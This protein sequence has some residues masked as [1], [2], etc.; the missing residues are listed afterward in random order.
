MRVRVVTKPYKRTKYRYEGKDLTREELYKVFG[1]R[2]AK[3]YDII[4]K[5]Q[6]GLLE[7]LEILKAI[8][9]NKYGGRNSVLKTIDE[10]YIYKVDRIKTE[11]NESEIEIT[12]TICSTFGCNN[13]LSMTEKLYGDR[14][15]A[16]N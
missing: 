4:K 12:E 6:V 8:G 16:C 11:T 7:A 15:C 9:M 1:M 5:Y 14:C 13:K 3:V 10:K 2:P